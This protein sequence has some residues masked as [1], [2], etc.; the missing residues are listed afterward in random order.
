MAH[1]Q[2]SL[3]DNSLPKDDSNIEKDAHITNWYLFC[4]TKEKKEISKKAKDL[5]KI[6]FPENYKEQSLNDLLLKLIRDEHKKNFPE[7]SNEG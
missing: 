7:K 5:L 6:H 2:I 3:F 4:F 1:Q